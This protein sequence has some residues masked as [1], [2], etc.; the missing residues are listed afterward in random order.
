M[1]A[2]GDPLE[3][4]G[5]ASTPSADEGTKRRCHALRDNGPPPNMLSVS[6]N[7]D[8]LPWCSIA[9]L[10]LFVVVGAALSHGWEMAPLRVV[11]TMA[12]QRRL[13]CAWNHRLRKVPCHP[14]IVAHARECRVLTLSNQHVVCCRLDR[15]NAGD[16]RRRCP[17]RLLTCRGARP[18][19]GVRSGVAGILAFGLPATLAPGTSHRAILRRRR[20][21]A[22]SS[23]R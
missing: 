12:P 5:D 4:Q 13:S 21:P 7:G 6:C 8:L 10:V 2:L 3:N 1:K 11:P 15:R 22:P 23:G 20:A 16:R 14:V 18:R 19:P 17:L 9:R